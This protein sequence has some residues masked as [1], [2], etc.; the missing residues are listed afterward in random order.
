MCPHTPVVIPGREE[1]HPTAVGSTRRKHL[2]TAKPQSDKEPQ[3]A[4]DTAIIRDID[5]M[6][7][8]RR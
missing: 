3:E 1:P 6:F 4:I 7:N 5:L 8:V 2:A